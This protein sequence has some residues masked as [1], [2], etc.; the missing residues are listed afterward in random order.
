MRTGKSQ[1]HANPR[2]GAYRRLQENPVWRSVLPFFDRRY[3][4]LLGL[5]DLALLRQVQAGRLKGSFAA[6]YAAH[7]LEDPELVGA[8]A[9]SAPK[10]VG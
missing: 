1:F 2:F 6:E 7:L 8:I 5:L 10:D 9:A 3:V 4:R